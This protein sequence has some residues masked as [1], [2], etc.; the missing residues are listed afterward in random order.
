MRFSSR[1]LAST[2]SDNVLLKS[3]KMNHEDSYFSTVSDVSKQKG[4]KMNNFTRK[5]NNSSLELL[6]DK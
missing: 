2:R 5:E 1:N 6:F 3:K 4:S